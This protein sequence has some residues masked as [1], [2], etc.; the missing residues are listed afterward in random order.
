M[1]RE[2]LCCSIILIG[3]LSGCSE[4]LPP[5]TG[6]YCDQS[7]SDDQVCLNNTCYDTCSIN[8]PCKGMFVCTG[9]L[10][11]PAEM[12]CTPDT[13]QCSAD[14]QSVEFC[15]DGS[16][17]SIES[18]CQEDE[19]CE[20]AVCVKKACEDGIMRCRD[21]NV[22][23]CLNSS[24]TIY[25]KCVSPQICAEN[26]F[27]CEIPAECFNDD[28]RCDPNGNIQI[29]SDEHW[30]SFKTCPNGTACDTASLECIETAACENGT[31]KCNGD[32]VYACA[33]SQWIRQKDC[34]NGQ[35]CQGGACIMSNCQNGDKRCFEINDTHFVQVCENN[36]WN[37]SPCETNA[38]CIENDE[39]AQCIKNNCSSQYKCENNILYKCD[40]Y[41]YVE[42]KNCGMTQYCDAI[43][44]SCK[45]KCGNGVIDLDNDEECDG[46]AIRS[47][48]SC[49]SKVANTSGTLKCTKDCKVD[50]S[51]CTMSCTSGTAECIGTTYR[52]CKNGSWQITE[53]ADSGQ[54]CSNTNGCY[55]PSVSGDWDVIQDF[56]E[57]P[58]ISTT[59]TSVYTIKYDY[60]DKFNVHWDM[61]GRINMQNGSYNYSLAG[62][63]FII[64]KE[65]GNYISAD[66]ING[67]IK[68]FA[69]DW[70]SWPKDTG[71]ITIEIG[72]I[73]ETLSF[74]GESEKQ[75]YEL[76]VND[77]SASTIRLTASSG[78]RFI[79]DNIRWTKMN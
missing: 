26:S 12:A 75:I 38:I 44:A 25:S 8:K 64:R 29:C 73:R 57:L 47:D 56:E 76:D 7:C 23:I 27:E 5:E 32:T 58:D 74:S 72:S 13:R 2:I 48:L 20:N 33:N 40:G 19:T 63:G 65:N 11:E 28:R 51:G 59:N 24:F 60:T 68:H 6:M 22:E 71:K 18:V 43:T 14:K 30:V 41:D 16:A 55:E 77:A 53:C 78:K 46:S 1:K 35:I 10:C 49:Q 54:V 37:S 9:F 70:R 79:I 31:F 36:A 67:G 3:L 62:Q 52:I 45:D 15:A 34:E 17:Y 4:V 39:G 66:N 61:L 42:D 50:A 21:N 69:F